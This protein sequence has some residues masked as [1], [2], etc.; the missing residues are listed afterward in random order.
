[1]DGL[2]K[3]GVTVKCLI[4]KTQNSVFFSFLSFMLNR[5]A[6]QD[7]MPPKDADI[8]T[9]SADSDQTSVCVLE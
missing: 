7:E 2:L 5:V 4:L 3:R 1:M 8:M 9:R 6:L